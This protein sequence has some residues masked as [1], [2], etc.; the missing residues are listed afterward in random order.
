MLAWDSAPSPDAGLICRGM[1]SAPQTVADRPTLAAMPSLVTLADR[2]ELAEAVRTMPTGVPPF[3][4]N[5]PMSWNF[6]SLGTLFPDYQLALL[7]DDAVHEHELVPD[8]AA[9]V[10]VE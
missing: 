5:D 7:D 10:V 1:A 9:L 2:P 4:V 6:A 8:A 3:I